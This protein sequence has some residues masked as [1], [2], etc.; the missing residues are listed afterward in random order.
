MGG[1]AASKPF[2]LVEK[3]GIALCDQIAVAYFCFLVHIYC[4]VVFYDFFERKLYKRVL[5]LFHV[6]LHF[7]VVRI[8]KGIVHS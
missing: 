2:Y 8:H 3:E 7:C 4:K 6:Y 5:F 1:C